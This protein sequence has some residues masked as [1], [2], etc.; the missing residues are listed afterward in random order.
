MAISRVIT[1]ALNHLEVKARAKRVKKIIL[2]G[3]A[4]DRM[5]ERGIVLEDIEK[6]LQSGSTCEPKYENGS[7]RYV[8]MLDRHDLCCEHK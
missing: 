1:E 5:F 8:M 6:V 4:E 2:S 3:H 7:W